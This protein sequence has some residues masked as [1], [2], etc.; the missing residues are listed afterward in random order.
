MFSNY[1]LVLI[2]LVICLANNL[3]MLFNI[4]SLTRGP[5]VF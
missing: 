5:R 1:D 3:D 4:F 2:R